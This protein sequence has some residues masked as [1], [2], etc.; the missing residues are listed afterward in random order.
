LTSPGARIRVEPVGDGDVGRGAVCGTE[1]LSAAATTTSSGSGNRKLRTPNPGRPIGTDTTRGTPEPNASVQTSGRAAPVHGEARSATEGTSPIA[2]S[3]L[4][5]SGGAV[6]YQ[7]RA[8]GEMLTALPAGPPRWPRGSARTARPDRTSRPGRRT[9]AESAVD[10]LRPR[11]APPGGCDQAGT[12]RAA[13]SARRR[14]G[15]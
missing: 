5:T 1:A 13:A 4:S 10:P 6:G 9:A 8:S 3:T 11:P 2:G 14:A 7:L 12:P 15:Q